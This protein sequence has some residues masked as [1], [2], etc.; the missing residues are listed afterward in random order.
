MD[1][2][3]NQGW[4]MYYSCNCNGTPKEYWSHPSFPTY[5]IRTRPKRNTFSILS[6]NMIIHGPAWGYT[7]EQALKDFNIYA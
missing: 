1:L 6:K 3:K 2:L 7:L 4:T 5:E